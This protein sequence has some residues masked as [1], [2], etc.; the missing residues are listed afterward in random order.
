MNRECKEIR[1][2]GCVGRTPAV[3]ANTQVMFALTRSYAA[4][5]RKRRTY[6]GRSARL[7]IA[8]T[9][10]G[11]AIRLFHV[12][13]DAAGVKAKTPRPSHRRDRYLVE[14]QDGAAGECATV[15]VTVAQRCG[16]P[17]GNEATI[18]AVTKS[19]SATLT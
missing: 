3:T 14:Q 1:Q 5:L 8:T 7:Q 2:L 17:A 13:L 4:V 6:Q 9:C 11:E 15:V 10:V 12:K 19:K 16:L 18:H